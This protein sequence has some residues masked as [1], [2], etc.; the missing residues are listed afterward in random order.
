M[1]S[2]SPAGGPGGYLRSERVQP[3]KMAQQCAND[4]YRRFPFLED[5]AENAFEPG[6]IALGRGHYR[7]VELERRTVADREQRVLELD[8]AA[9]AGIERQ[10]FEFGA[11]QQP[12]A[13]E[14]LDEILGSVAARGDPVRRQTVAD[15]R[16]TV[17]RRVGIAADRRRPGRSFEGAAQRRAGR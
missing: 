12:V 4:R 6:H 5:P 15:H 14:M 2:A 11:G 9:L 16:G 7:V 8:P 17:A 3:V 1:R 13:A 10:L